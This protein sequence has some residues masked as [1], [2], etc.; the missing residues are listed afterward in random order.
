MLLKINQS[1][2]LQ[3]QYSPFAALHD[4]INRVLGI[5]NFVELDNVAVACFLQDLNLSINSSYIGLFFDA[6]LFQYL[7]GNLHKRLKSMITVA[8]P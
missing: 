5:Q 7:D 4:Q 8:A 3:A 2:S 1:A 6:T